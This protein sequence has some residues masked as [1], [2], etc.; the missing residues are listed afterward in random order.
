M[1]NNSIMGIA[2]RVKQ[3]RV[4][5]GM[6]QQE[7]AEELYFAS[8]STVANFESG[9]RALTI[10]A[11]IGYSNF[12]EVSLDWILKGEG[13]EHELPADV[14]EMQELYSGLASEALK[15]VAMEQIKALSSL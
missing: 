9:M 4:D 14:K 10:D 8:R 12:F 7:V 3:L 11:A 13:A 5:A 2:E 15:K 6:S 1:E